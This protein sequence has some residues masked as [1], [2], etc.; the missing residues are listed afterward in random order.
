MSPVK[1]MG[2]AVVTVVLLSIPRSSPGY[3]SCCGPCEEYY[4]PRPACCEDMC[5]VFPQFCFV[6][7]YPSA[8]NCAV[9]GHWEKCRQYGYWQCMNEPEPCIVLLA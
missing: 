3:S 9:Q 5:C 8:C 2:L 1:A 6:P 7:E 4:N